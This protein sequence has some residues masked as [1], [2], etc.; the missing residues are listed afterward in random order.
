MFSLYL[1]SN[2]MDIIDTLQLYLV[3]INLLITIFSRNYSLFY[4]F[5]FIFFLS[6]AP[7]YIFSIRKYFKTLLL[8]MVTLILHHVSYEVMN[9]D[10]DFLK[11]YSYQVLQL[12]SPQV[13]LKLMFLLYFS[14]TLLFA[15]FRIRILG[16]RVRSQVLYQH[17]PLFETCTVSLKVSH[18]A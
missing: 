9:L 1:F 10:L 14:L 18:R 5:I 15:L 12:F 13:K 4:L 17:K 11:F 2:R 8:I 6:M 7:L 16:H 3:I